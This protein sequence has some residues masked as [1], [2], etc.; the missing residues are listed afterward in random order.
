MSK[1]PVGIENLTRTRNWIKEIAGMPTY[2]GSALV[3][4][5]YTN[6]NF[7]IG[8][9]VFLCFIV[10]YYYVYEYLFPKF[11]TKGK[12]KKLA[13]FVVIQIIFWGSILVF[14]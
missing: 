13:L 12:K 1:L 11:D 4:I 9:A 6:N 8:T 7:L 10:I 14:F 5:K 2:I 3:T